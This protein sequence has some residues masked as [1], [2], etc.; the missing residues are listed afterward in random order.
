MLGSRTLFVVDSFKKYVI[1]KDQTK[2]SFMSW[3]VDFSKDESIYR[4]YPKQ[5]FYFFKVPNDNEMYS[6]S[7]QQKL[8][9][10]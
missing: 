7:L 1:T 6:C 4:C 9:W 8:R 2:Q 3:C 10:L 5:K